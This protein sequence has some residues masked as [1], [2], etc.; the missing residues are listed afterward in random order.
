M[1]AVTVSFSLLSALLNAVA[2]ILQRRATGQV[3]PQHLFHHRILSAVIRSR[4]W[5]TGVALQ[6]VGFFAQAVAL[7]GGSLVLVAPL[8]TTDL[9][10]LVA[11]F[12]FGFG[13]R[14]GVREWGAVALLSAGLGGLLTATNPH[15]GSPAISFGHW[16]WAF[17]IITVLIV[18]GALSMRRIRS[19]PIRAVLGG[20]TAG[21]HFAF[22]AVLTK[23]VLAQLE[24]GALH[25]F[26]SW[27][28]YALIIV[29]ISSALTMQSMY[30]SGPLTITQ[31]ALE[32]VEAAAGIAFGLLLFGDHVNHSS[33]ALAASA[34]SG[35]VLF[36]GIILLASSKRLQPGQQTT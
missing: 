2:A 30:G 28:L 4:L 25:E 21:L 7:H 1:I 20:A 23:L 24:H 16:L 18:A 8:L 14:M 26:V 15:G 35:F 32:I 11:L 9:I 6:V 27:Q 17:V 29:G 10:F 5:L 34:I 3:A 19:I 31:P 13:F 36:A 12:H 33:A 22:T